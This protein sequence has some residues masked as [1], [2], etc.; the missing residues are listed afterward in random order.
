MRSRVSVMLSHLRGVPMGKALLLVT[1][2]ASSLYLGLFYPS[3]GAHIFQADN[4]FVLSPTQSAPI[5]SHQ[6]SVQTNQIAFCH[7]GKKIFLTTG[8]GRVKILSYPD[9]KPIFYTSYDPGLPFT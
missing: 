1:R 7:S 5:A 9:F 4:L 3:L 2:Y 6:Q 8:E